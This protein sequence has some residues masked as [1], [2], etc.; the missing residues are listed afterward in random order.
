VAWCLDTI[1]RH[2]DQKMLR[3]APDIFALNL[4]STSWNVNQLKAVLKPLK[5]KDG[6][7]M[8]TLKVKLYKRWLLWRGRTAPTMDAAGPLD[9]AAPLNGAAPLD[10]VAPVEEA[11]VEDY[12]CSEEE[13]LIAAM[14]MFNEDKNVHEPFQQ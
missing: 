11:D 10:G 8:P 13:E 2:H 3:D 9:G 5:T 1:V 4:E 7:A 12:G 6:T 14:M